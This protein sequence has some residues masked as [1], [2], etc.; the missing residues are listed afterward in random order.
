M[1]RSVAIP[2]SS[3]ARNATEWHNKILA[4]PSEPVFRMNG[5]MKLH[6]GS[7]FSDQ[8]VLS[9]RVIYNRYPQKGELES[10]HGDLIQTTTTQ[11]VSSKLT[12]DFGILEDAVSRSEYFESPTKELMKTAGQWVPAIECMHLIVTRA[13]EE[14]TSF[15][16][17]SENRPVTRS[18]SR[19]M[20]AK[21]TAIDNQVEEDVDSTG[22]DLSIL[23]IISDESDQEEQSFIQSTSHRQEV[24]KEKMDEFV[25]GDEQTVNAVL[26]LLIMP[27]ASIDGVYGRV[28]FD[29]RQYRVINEKECIFSA[30][31]DGI[32]LGQFQGKPEYLRTVTFFEA[33]RALSRSDDAT[34]R[35]QIC[36]EMAAIIHNEDDLGL[37]TAPESRFDDDADEAGSAKEARTPYVSCKDGTR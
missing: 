24:E 22:Q 13:T 1:M 12:K 9:T 19:L 8:N 16:K 29:R 35:R 18:Q 26:I 11:L 6:P 23:T 5:Q 31:V 25:S 37:V 36:A 27:L 34:Y 20:P 28:R 33:K 15:V 21:D 7:S 32:V 10:Q 14:E 3:I 4:D 17:P 30:K 2:V